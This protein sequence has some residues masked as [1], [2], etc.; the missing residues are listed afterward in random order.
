MP[1]WPRD[2]SAERPTWIP[3][4]VSARC[5]ARIGWQGETRHCKHFSWGRTVLQLPHVRRQSSRGHEE[6]IQ[7]PT[8][9][10]PE[11][12]LGRCRNRCL[13]QPCCATHRL[14]PNLSLGQTLCHSRR[15]QQP[16]TAAAAFQQTFAAYLPKQNTCCGAKKTTI[17]ARCPGLCRRHL[18]LSPQE[19]VPPTS[20]LAPMSMS[21]R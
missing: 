7:L 20:S 12:A 16:R 15:F 13:S 18:E 8:L 14:P 3:T 4:A 21:H 2:W 19:L 11:H 17:P 10:L 5:S 6:T 9:L 1:S